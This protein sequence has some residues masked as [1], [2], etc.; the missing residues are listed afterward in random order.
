MVGDMPFN[1]LDC[2]YRATEEHL[3]AL[4]THAETGVGHL[5]PKRRPQAIS[6]GAC[7]WG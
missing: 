6:T 3:K 7:G 5:Q 4:Q 1:M 2:R